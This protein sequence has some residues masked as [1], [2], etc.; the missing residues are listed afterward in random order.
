MDGVPDGELSFHR[1][2]FLLFLGYVGISFTVGVFCCGGRKDF[3]SQ[4][5]ASP[6]VA[7]LP[8]HSAQDWA[9][10]RSFDRVNRFVAAMDC[11]P[12]LSV[13]RA[14][15]VHCMPWTPVC[16]WLGT[17]KAAS[18]SARTCFSLHVRIM[19]LR[20]VDTTERLVQ[21]TKVI[22]EARWMNILALK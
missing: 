17:S 6:R 3:F 4:S 16:L 1:D 12:T 13:L 15:T 8:R 2:G 10:C 7:V 19:S 5:P 18:I 11:M 21:L 20:G 22:A 14:Q 9:V